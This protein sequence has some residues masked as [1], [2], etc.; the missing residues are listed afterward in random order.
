LSEVVIELILFACLVAS[1]VR[2]IVFCIEASNK[3]LR[4]ST[5]NAWS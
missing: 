1:S 2:D 5:G 4:S 3:S